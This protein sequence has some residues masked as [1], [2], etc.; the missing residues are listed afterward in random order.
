MWHDGTEILREDQPYKDKLLGD[1]FK[2]GEERLAGMLELVII[3]IWDEKLLQ[4]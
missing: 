3:K 4:P 2:C 1:L